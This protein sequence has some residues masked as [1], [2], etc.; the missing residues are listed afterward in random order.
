[1]QKPGCGDILLGTQDTLGCTTAKYVMGWKELDDAEIR[2]HPKYTKDWDQANRFVKTRKQLPKGLLAFATVP[3][4]KAPIEPDVIHGLSDVLQ[5]Y[6]LGN[7][8]CA[9]HDTPPFK[10]SMTMNSS[11]V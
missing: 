2:S 1:M 10:M 8:W 9:V 3:L 7:D 5:A 6:H 11:T 4:H